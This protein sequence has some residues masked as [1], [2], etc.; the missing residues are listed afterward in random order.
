MGFKSCSQSDTDL[1]MKKDNKN[2]RELYYRYLSV[3][4]DDLLSIGEDAYLPINMLDQFFRRREGSLG[5]KDRY[6]GENSERT[7]TTDGR[8]IW[9]MNSQ[10]YMKN[11]IEKVN[12]LARE[13]GNTL[14]KRGKGKNPMLK[15]YL[16]ELDASK[17]LEDPDTYQYLIGM[18]RCSRDL[19][20]ID[21]LTEVIV[22][23]PNLCNPREV[24]LDAVFHIFNYLNVNREIIPGKLVFDDL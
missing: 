4:V 11:D 9:S 3:Y 2:N 14:H 24:H 10:D 8:V 16:P 17:E 6:M 23:S 19:A 18:L 20:W 1:Y 12:K 22:L 13:D 7:Q 5:Y 21:I 15:D